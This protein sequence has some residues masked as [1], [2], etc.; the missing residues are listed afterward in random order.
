[1]TVPTAHPTVHLVPR[2]HWEREWYEPFQRFRLRL[3]DL[4]HEVLDW[5]DED[6]RFRSTLD[7]QMAA[8]DDDLEVRLVDDEHGPALA[9]TVLRCTGQISRDVHPYREEPAGPQLPTPQALA[10]AG[11]VLTSARRRPGDAGALELRVVRESDEPGTAVLR[12]PFRS[13][14]RVDL[15]G[16]P[17]A[18]LDVTSEP[19]GTGVLELPLRPWEIATVRLG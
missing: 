8:V 15:L 11:A 12:G 3:V 6:P 9:L 19:D 18:P 13:A 17:G 1:M 16:R 5:A 7:G 4:L 14:G 10:V 2:T